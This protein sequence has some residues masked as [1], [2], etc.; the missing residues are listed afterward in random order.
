MW[1]TNNQIGGAPHHR[2][3]CPLLVMHSKYPL[4]RSF[5]NNPI[6]CVVTISLSHLTDLLAKLWQDW[7]VTFNG[8]DWII[9]FVV[10][11]WWI[12]EEFNYKRCILLG[13]TRGFFNNEK[14][15]WKKVVVVEIGKGINNTGT[16][17][18]T[19]RRQERT[20]IMLSKIMRFNCSKD[21]LFPY[22]P[23]MH[24]SVLPFI[25]ELYNLEGG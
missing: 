22:K 21:D 10:V 24:S 13:S 18:C 1:R 6:N 7:S 8:C 11:V 4:M 2:L 14:E 20:R 17:Q 25:Q 5:V 23:I 3:S 12:G 9:P 15:H 19:L 16:A